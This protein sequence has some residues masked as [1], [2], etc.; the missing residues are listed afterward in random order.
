MTIEHSLR[1]C[2]LFLAALPLSV[3]VSAQTDRGTVQFSTPEGAIMV[4]YGRPLLKGRDPLTWQED[5]N[6][7]RI[8]M[9]AM[10][11]LRTPVDLTFGNVRIA[12]GNYGLWLLKESS[13]RY[14]LV[15]NSDTSG[16]GMDH[17]KTKDVG[18]V[19]LRKEPVTEAVEAFTIEL[20]DGT[21]GGVFALTWGTT[22]LA[23]DFRLRK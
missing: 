7:W 5:G 12:K 16:M 17:D 23:T 18:S 22:R 13:G 8:G 1:I 10:T 14:E 2:V 3:P 19:P 6:Y 21:D 15:F 20:K 4:D 11:T 9:N